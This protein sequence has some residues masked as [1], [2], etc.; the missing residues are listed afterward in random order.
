[1]S[2]SN[3]IIALRADASVI[4][5]QPVDPAH[6]FDQGVETGKPSVRSHASVCVC[7]A[8]SIDAGATSPARRRRTPAPLRG[9]AGVELAQRT[10]GAVARVRQRA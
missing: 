3:G 7:V 5:E 6:G 1:M 9:D 8:G 2:N 10:G 4:V